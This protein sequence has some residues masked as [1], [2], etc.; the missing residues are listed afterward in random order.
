MRKE[1]K[2]FS[3]RQPNVLFE[4][5]Y[6]VTFLVRLNKRNIFSNKQ[7]VI[8]VSAHQLISLGNP[9]WPNCI[10]WQTIRWYKQSFV[11]SSYF[12]CIL[13]LPL[14][15]ESVDRGIEW[16]FVHFAR[17]TNIFSSIENFLTSTRCYFSPNT[18]FPTFH[19]KKHLITL[20]R[21]QTTYSLIFKLETAFWPFWICKSRM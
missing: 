1:L 19:W 6:Q 16:T 15:V 9:T 20:G 3:F 10:I 14:F 18:S 12:F 4:R 8:S 2:I 21:G 5:R 7:S 11:S 17:N 13:T